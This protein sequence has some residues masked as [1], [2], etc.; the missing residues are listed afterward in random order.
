MC[1]AE[2]ADLCNSN[3]IKFCACLP[4]YALTHGWIELTIRSAVNAVSYC[5]SLQSLASSSDRYSNGKLV[6][7]NYSGDRSY[8]DL[9]K[10]IEDESAKYA[11]TQLLKAPADDEAVFT[12]A[13][14]NLDGKI[15]ELGEDELKEI[16]GK[17][18]VL[19]EYFAPWCGQ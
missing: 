5:S 17:G 3:G 1:L 18:P 9:N 12:T 15:L 6:E 2:Q 4:N 13:R 14:P 7:P 8:D 16:K 19:V 10:F 11:S